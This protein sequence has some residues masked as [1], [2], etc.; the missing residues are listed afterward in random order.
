MNNITRYLLLILVA[1]LAAGVVIPKAFKH[2][3]YALD[4]AYHDCAFRGVH[5]ILD[6]PIERILLPATG[7][8]VITNATGMGTDRVVIS[9]DT[10]SFFGSH[11]ASTLVS[12]L[13]QP[14][15]DLMG[16]SISTI[17]WW[18]ENGKIGTQKYIN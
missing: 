9:T 18:Q 11:Y 16:G 8:T 15:G 2:D 5:E 6:N 10:Y 13:K 7:R 14:N 4:P 3:T 17:R 12:C 1:G